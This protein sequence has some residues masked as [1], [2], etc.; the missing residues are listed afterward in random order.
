MAAN[1]VSFFYFTLVMVMVYDERI[2]P[3]KGKNNGS[4]TVRKILKNK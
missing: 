1:V 3:A 2:L 4:G